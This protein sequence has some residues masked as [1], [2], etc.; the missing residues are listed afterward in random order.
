PVH[1]GQGPGISNNYQLGELSGVETV[2]LTV[3]QIPAH[4]HVLFGSGGPAT[5][6][7]PA[8]NLPAEAS[9]RFFRPVDTLTPM[10][11]TSSSGGAQPH[12]NMMP[13]LC[14]SFIISLFGIFPTQ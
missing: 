13:T 11:P 1:T 7:V 14:V 10:A 4:S 9:K 3:S 2:T 6:T 8:N 12:E 5:D